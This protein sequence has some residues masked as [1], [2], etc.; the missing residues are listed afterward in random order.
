MIYR[1]LK[2]LSLAGLAGL[3]AAAAPSATPM[4]V[5][6]LLSDD[7]G[8]TDMG[9]NNPRT[10]YET[11]NLD[12]FARQ[13]VR[14]TNGYAASPV[15]SPTRY[16]VQTGRYP[17]RVGLT[18]WLPGVRTERFQEAPLTQQ[19]P[20]EETTL[21]EVLKTAGYRTAFVGKWHLGEEEKYWPEAQ[22]YDIN[23]AGWSMGRPSSYFSPYQNPRLEDGPMGEHLTERLANETLKI[24]TEFKASDRPFFLM[25]SFYDVHTPLQ[26]R[27]ALI[28]KYRAKAKRLGLTDAFIGETQ[29]Y[30]SAKG[31]RQT[32][33]VQRH[34]VY[35]AMVEEMDTAFGRIL[36]RL[37]ELGLADN[38]LVIFASD[39]G[40][41]STAEGSPTSNLPLRGGKGWVYEGGIREPWV[42]RLPGA[43]HPGSASAVPI[44]STD[45][46]PTA[47]AAVGVP[48]PQGLEI[49]GRNLVPL[50]HGGPPPQR[51]ALFWHYPHYGNQGGF[52]GGAVRMGDWKLIENYE[53]GSV[54]LYNLRS[55]IGEHRDLAP[56]HAVRVN[57][58][59]NRLHAWYRET[60][61][62]FLRARDGG[63]APWAPDAR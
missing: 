42:I 40:G 48:V 24:L 25:H 18:N 23:V 2:V 16:S 9:A 57:A 27:P 55:D 37:D 17:T 7:Y 1:S 58:M 44:M 52:P 22:G 28:E 39:N 61:A 21:A 14:F 63:P 35:A 62:K 31:P 33:T 45:I 51:D 30:L 3:G 38:T 5:I 34:A 4:N 20:L 29:Y 46:F 26:A 56:A 41:L 36:A 10:F 53:D 12:R 13:G 43:A 54:A 60:G 59:R 47:L 19:M 6:V 50:L 49:D 15:C 11:P 8:W 32:R